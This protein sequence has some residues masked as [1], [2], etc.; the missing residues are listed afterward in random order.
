MSKRPPPPAVELSPAEKFFGLKSRPFSLTPDLRFVY[1]SRSHTHAL[2]QLT[3]SLKRREGL[4]IVTGSIGTGKTMLCRTLL[5]TFDARM[6]LSL[7]LDP[8]LEVEDLLRKLLAD[9]GIMKE[10]EDQPAGPMTNATRHR[11]VVTLQQFLASLIPLKAHAVVMIDEAQ[12]L[13]PRVLEELRLLSNFETDEAK[14][15]QIVLVGQ[16]DLD[17]LL[18]RPE[19]R[20]LNQRVARRCELEPLSQA[21]V[22]DY[23]ERRLTV[24]SQPAGESDVRLP[25]SSD[26][27]TVRFTPDGAATV[28]MISGGVPRLVNTLSDR[29]L[30]VAYEQQ[31]REVD[32]T[33]V[34][35][36]AERLRL[37]IPSG[38]PIRRPRKWL[39]AAAL[40]ALLA[41]LA[42]AAWWW[43]NARAGG[44]VTAPPARF[45]P[46]SVPPAAS[47][48][49]APAD[50]TAPPPAASPPR[51]T[52][53]A[54][55][56][57]APASPPATPSPPQRPAPSNAASPLA[58]NGTSPGAST[59]SSAAAQAPSAPRAPSPPAAP[60]PATSQAANT[61]GTTVEPA[62]PAVRSDADSPDA[63]PPAAD[64]PAPGSF[65]IAVASFRTQQRA[66]LAAQTVTRLTLPVTIRL[67]SDAGWYRVISGPYE[68][69]EAAEEAQE[70]LGRR[71]YSGTRITRVSPT[72]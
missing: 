4:V 21:E 13:S 1:H 5:E 6:F 38:L 57:A 9:F 25:A 10:F 68:T 60:V 62:S 23:I 54:A 71:G 61:S 70:R 29:A 42:G 66:Q 56:S 50:P 12:H 7:V 24:A 16:P 46:A 59:S 65:M 67:D 49:P 19:L 35:E 43:W 48:T 41:L 44:S 64:A 8:G 47:Q 15:L 18:Q 72:P 22:S 26:G 39:L 17:D 27:E 63:D 3:S 40:V 2:E 53:G 31:Q 51:G 32:P 69:R 37:V 11:Y 20:Q 55:R 45:A 28:A 52:A 34:I 30:D 14:L 33:I 58:S 36:A